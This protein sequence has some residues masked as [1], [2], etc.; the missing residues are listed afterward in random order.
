V[1]S[2]Q[3]RFGILVAVTESLPDQLFCIKYYPELSNLTSDLSKAPT[4]RFDDLSD[5]SD[6][7]TCSGDEPGMDYLQGKV[8]IVSGTNSSNCSIADRAEVIEASVSAGE[9]IYLNPNVFS[10]RV[11]FFSD[12]SRRW[13]DR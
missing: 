7:D 13:P 10:R 9:M 1:T 3:T 2:A 8:G 6:V 11:L 4:Y 5:I 12:S